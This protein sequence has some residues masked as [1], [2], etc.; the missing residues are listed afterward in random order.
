MALLEQKVQN[1]PKGARKPLH[2]QRDGR[3]NVLASHKPP[4]G[5][6]TGRRVCG[7]R[8]SIHAHRPSLVQASAL[9][10]CH[11]VRVEGKYPRPLVGLAARRRTWRPRQSQKNHQGLIKPQNI[12]IMDPPDART[13]LG[14]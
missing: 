9:A 2:H 8:A 14:L 1:K 5:A 13:D 6:A 7:A 11:F 4:F 3:Q 12:F 10:L